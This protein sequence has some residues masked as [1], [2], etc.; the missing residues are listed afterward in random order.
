MLVST[1]EVDDRMAIVVNLLESSVGHAVSVKDDG[2]AWLR[3]F[4]EQFEEYDL[5]QFARLVSVM[6]VQ[7]RN[8]PIPLGMTLSSLPPV[9]A[10]DVVKEIAGDLDRTADL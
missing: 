6:G 4:V 5:Q 3:T 1:L 2:R 8:N 10:A 9:E 7:N